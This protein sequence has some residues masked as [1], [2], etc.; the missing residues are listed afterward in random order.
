MTEEEQRAAAY[1]AQCERRI[2]YQERQL[3]NLAGN[4]TAAQAVR[5]AWEPILC[6]DIQPR[7]ACDVLDD[8]CPV[9]TPPRVPGWIE[10]PER[11]RRS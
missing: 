8:P 2:A 10:L 7:T 1:R 3:A 11:Y 5:D 4:D 6:R 9:P